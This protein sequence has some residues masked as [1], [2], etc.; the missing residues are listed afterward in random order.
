MFNTSFLNKTQL[1]IKNIFF[2]YFTGSDPV[3]CIFS[4]ELDPV[5]PAR[6]QWRHAPLFTEQCSH[7]PR[8][9]WSMAT[10]FS[11]FSAC[12]KQQNTASGKLAA[13]P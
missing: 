12:K 11:D 6:E 10:L 2:Y 9:Q 3:Q 13:Q 1:K 8:E 5:Q 4:F 7:D